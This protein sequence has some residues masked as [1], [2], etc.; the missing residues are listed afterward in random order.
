MPDPMSDHFSSEEQFRSFLIENDPLDATS[1]T[2]RIDQETQEIMEAVQTVIHDSDMFPDESEREDALYRITDYI[3]HQECEVTTDP[4]RPFRLAGTLRN[5][6]SFM[7]FKDGKMLKGY[8]KTLYEK[9]LEPENSARYEQ[10]RLHFLNQY[11]PENENPPHPNLHQRSSFNVTDAALVTKDRTVQLVGHSARWLLRN[12]L[13]VP[14]MVMGSE[15]TTTL[16]E[17][18]TALGSQWGQFFTTLGVSVGAVGII[19]FY[20]LWCYNKGTRTLERA[21]KSFID[22][23]AAIVVGNIA[24]CVANVI[25]SCIFGPLGFWLGLAVQ[26]AVGWGVGAVT[27]HYVDKWTTEYYNIPKAEAI[28]NAYKTLGVTKD[29]T[30]KEINKKCRE[31]S[32][33]HHPDYLQRLENPPDEQGI[34]EHV[35][36]F[37]KI[38]NAYKFIKTMREAEASGRDENDN[39]DWKQ[40]FMLFVKNL[41]SIRT[42]NSM[43]EEELMKAID[44]EVIGFPPEESLQDPPQTDNRNHDP[45]APLP[46]IGVEN[47]S[48]SVAHTWW[49]KFWTAIGNH[50]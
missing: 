31:M 3:N 17:V 47:R 27:R 28:E 9:S 36:E 15:I 18:L 44:F 16:D 6:K 26:A 38:Q 49:Q 46:T 24:G 34:E 45:D 37:I 13:K 20:N 29:A 19:A 8:I 40:N 14:P 22:N 21:K 39:L 32:R 48:H 5:I 25:L 35:N 23:S 50:N 2:N 10:W 41:I 7:K 11:L 43:K 4:T 1:A 33:E 30:D 42:K 12:V